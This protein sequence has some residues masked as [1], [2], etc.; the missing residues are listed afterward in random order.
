MRKKL[1]IS[2]KVLRLWSAFL[3]F[4]FSLTTFGYAS[5]WTRSDNNYYYPPKFSHLK[6]D[7]LTSFKVN[8][9]DANPYATTGIFFKNSQL[10]LENNSVTAKTPDD[11]NVNIQFDAQNFYPNGSVRFAILTIEKPVNTANEFEVILSSEFKTLSEK[12]VTPLKPNLKIIINRSDLTE[13]T[14]TL[15]NA[16]S[17]KI[18]WRSGNLVDIRRYYAPVTFDLMVEFDVT[19]FANGM[20]RN[21]IVMRYDRL[22]ETPMQ[23]ITYNMA[24]LMN[25]KPYK[26]YSDI[27]QNHHSKFRI[28][29]RFGYKT[30]NITALNIS[31]IIDTGALAQYDITFGVNKKS[32]EHDYTNLQNANNSIRG[33]GLINKNFSATDNNDTIGLLPAWTTRYL[34]T[35][36]DKARQ[37]VL[38]QGDIA[39]YIPWHFIDAQT[40]QAPLPKNHPDLWINNRATLKNNK[41]APFSTKDTI[42]N[43]DIAHQPSFS[44]IPYVI[45]G[46]RYYYDTLVTAYSWSRFSIENKNY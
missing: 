27:K 10:N 20:I 39:A 2:K 15:N 14:V 35:S 5:D 8:I 22:Y 44:Y 41:I 25:N 28:P 11:I 29:I 34:M 45:T 26:N 30:D 16:V 3:I 19:T 9:T 40:N 4:L 42:W 37:I 43:I 33:N 12:K 24:I 1:I 38:V 17:E 21:D 7:D 13:K 23:S 18:P 32:I 31:K 36:H 6:T 46:D